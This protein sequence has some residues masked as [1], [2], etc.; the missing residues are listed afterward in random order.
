MLT[1]YGAN[2][3][4]S[5]DTEMDQ[6]T[7]AKRY[8]TKSVPWRRNIDHEL[9][10]IEDMCARLS[11]PQAQG[12]AKAERIRKAYDQRPLT[13]RPA[14]NGLPSSYYDKLF[15]EALRPHERFVLRDK[16]APRVNEW[17]RL[18]LHHG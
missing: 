9:N 8:V 18:T 17:P 1:T 13:K 5:E 10:L 3:M 14:P 2:G 11:L 7:F 6:R 16:A 15:L 4:S 12:R